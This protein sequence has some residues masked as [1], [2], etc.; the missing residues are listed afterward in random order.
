ML[1]ALRA[2]G[3]SY[4]AIARRYGCHVRTIEAIAEGKTVDPRWT[5]G[6][7]I[8]HEYRA[9]VPVGLATGTVCTTATT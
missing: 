5:L 4:A 9:I 6:V 7:F 3:V 1:L 8:E 2:H